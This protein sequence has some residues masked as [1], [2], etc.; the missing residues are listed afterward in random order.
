MAPTSKPCVKDTASIFNDAEGLIP[1]TN[2]A[3]SVLTLS[4]F[5]QDAANK[6]ATN[7]EITGSLNLVKFDMF[8]VV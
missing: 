8:V 2:D 6:L 4:L 7:S 3:A 5:W 1:A